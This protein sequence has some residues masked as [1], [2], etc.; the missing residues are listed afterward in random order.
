MYMHCYDSKPR[1]EHAVKSE[2]LD[3]FQANKQNAD[4]NVGLSK[5]TV[6]LLN[7]I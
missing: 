2:L 3:I 4:F 5:R 7:F 6:T 1:L